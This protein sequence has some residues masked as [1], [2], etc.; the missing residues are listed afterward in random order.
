MVVT[1]STAQDSCRPALTLQASRSTE[2]AMVLQFRPYLDPDQS[3]DGVDLTDDGSYV[4]LTLKRD[5]HCERFA[6]ESWDMIFHRLYEE[7]QESYG[8]GQIE[9]DERIKKEHEL[10]KLT[11]QQFEAMRDAPENTRR[12]IQPGI[13]A[14]QNIQRQIDML[15]VSSNIQGAFK[16]SS[17]SQSTT[18][19]PQKTSDIDRSLYDAD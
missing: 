3:T 6:D 12:S 8:L 9:R 18:K 14:R 2:T 4:E 19:Q 5:D 16:G 10:K 11:A 1:V 17:P 15:E 13:R 7:L